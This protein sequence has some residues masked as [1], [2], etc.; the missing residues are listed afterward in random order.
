MHERAPNT[1]R[2]DPRTAPDG[3]VARLLDL[4]EAWHRESR[5]GDPV[6][7]RAERAARLRCGPPFGAIE[8]HLLTAVGG[9]TVGFGSWD[10]SRLDNPQFAWLHVFVAPAARQGGA[11][12]ATLER[13]LGDAQA[14]GATE[15]GFGLWDHVPA[16]RDLRRRVEA[17][18]GLAPVYTERVARLDLSAVRRDDVAAALASRQ[19]RI[20]EGYRFLFF[21]MDELPD[22]ATGFRLDDYVRMVERIW[23][24]MPLEQMQLNDEVYSVEA[25]H[26]QVDRQ[27]SQGRLIWN[28]VA[29]AAPSGPSVGVT[30]IS[31]NPADPRRIEQ[32]D[33]GVLREHQGT[34]LGTAL[35]LRML[36]RV[37]DDLPAARFIDT[38]NAASNAAMIHVNHELGFRERYVQQVYQLPIDRL[39][40]LALPAGPAEAGG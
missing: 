19:A 32:W 21:V 39:R 20:S 17:D 29:M 30:N 25:F 10:I 38:E 3:V 18:W 31:F 37:L 11:G 1:T 6:P 16:S 9:E 27:R 40:A 4:Q 35:K 2:L 24:L 7:P 14:E 13:L 5:P 34:G 22:P 26:H 12:T 36:Q 28:E 15:A 8:G 23:N 33:T